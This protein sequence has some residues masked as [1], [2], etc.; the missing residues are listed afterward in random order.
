LNWTG[1]NGNPMQVNGLFGVEEARLKALPTESVVALHQADALGLA[2]AQLMSLSNLQ[3]VLSGMP[4]GAQP[5]NGLKGAKVSRQ[6]SQ[7]GAKESSAM[8]G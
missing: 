3:F 7:K 5:D 6:R 4:A 1:E 2:Y 8:L